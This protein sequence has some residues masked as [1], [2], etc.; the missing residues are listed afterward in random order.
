VSMV[1]SALDISPLRG[2]VTLRDKDYEVPG[3]TAEGILYLLQRFPVLRAML[4]N[5]ELADMTADGLIAMAPEVV[6]CIIAVGLGH[7][8]SPES[9]TSAGNLSL[10]EKMYVIEKIMEVT[11][12]RGIGPFKE[13]L[14]RLGS[15]AVGPGWEQAT[16]SARQSSS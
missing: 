2:T 9:E 11:L 5:R 3:V 1:A 14:D 16:K 6:N 4:V 8:A 13:M 10:D 15:R 12:P 7:I